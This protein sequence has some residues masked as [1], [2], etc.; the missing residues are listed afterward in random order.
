MRFMSSGAFFKPNIVYS[1]MKWAQNVFNRIS[2]MFYQMSTDHSHSPHLSFARRRERNTDAK[3][4][5]R[6]AMRT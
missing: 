3:Y 6:M 1:N 5:F 4:M 2:S